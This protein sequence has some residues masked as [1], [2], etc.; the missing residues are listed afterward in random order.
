MGWAGKSRYPQ[1]FD[2]HQDPRDRR[3]RRL[4]QQTD[5]IQ[6]RRQRRR[7]ARPAY[8]TKFPRM[9]CWRRS[10]SSVMLWCGS[11]PPCWPWP[12]WESWSQ[13]ESPPA[14]PPPNLPSPIPP[15][16]WPARL[17]LPPAHQQHRPAAQYQSNRRRFR[18]NRHVVRRHEVKRLGKRRDIQRDRVIR[19]R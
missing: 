19:L 13:S 2:N 4:I 15:K 12:C 16:P 5:F 1:I 11:S 8:E 9:F 6:P 7:I 14:K 18:H 3:A 10:R 17:S